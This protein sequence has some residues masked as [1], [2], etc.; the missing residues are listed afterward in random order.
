M[1]N[2]IK[3]LKK[4]K[5]HINNINIQDCPSFE[6]REYLQGLYNGYEIALSLIENKKPILKDVENVN[7]SDI[8]HTGFDINN[9]FVPE[10]EINNNENIEVE[11]EQVC[12]QIQDIAEQLKN[13][14]N[15]AGF[16]LSELNKAI[17]GILNKKDDSVNNIPDKYGY[18]GFKKDVENIINSNCIENYSN[19]PDFILAEFLTDSLKNVA[20]L[21][22]N[23]DRW[24]SFNPWDKNKVETNETELYTVKLK[25]EDLPIY[26]GIISIIK[27]FS[28]NDSIPDETKKYFKNKFDK[29]FESELKDECKNNE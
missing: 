10:K 13:A 25:F 24:Y 17:E 21:T 9:H 18:N 28:L 5:E 16:S 22:N 14:A 2:V 4:L 12:S 26:D 27:E 20:K 8:F 6:E 15:S 23:R 7:L 29:L 3:S 11:N 19:T 1:D